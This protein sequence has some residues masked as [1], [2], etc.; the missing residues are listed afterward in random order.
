MQ[1]TTV[2]RMDANA[3]FVLNMDAHLILA[4]NVHF[5]IQHE[6]DRGIVDDAG[7]IYMHVG[8]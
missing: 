2:A 8:D 5:M 7:G 1:N 3:G 4:A 6:G